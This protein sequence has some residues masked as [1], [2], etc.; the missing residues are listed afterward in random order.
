MCIV[1]TISHSHFAPVQLAL[2]ARPLHGPLVVYDTPPRVNCMNWFSGVRGTKLKLA[3]QKM[4]C[5][6]IDTIS[7]AD[8][9]VGMGVVFMET[10]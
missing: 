10:V 6:F 2:R 7:P 8:L 1:G 5:A 4:L 9:R 3:V